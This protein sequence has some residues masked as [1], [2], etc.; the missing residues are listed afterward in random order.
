MEELFSKKNRFLVVAAHPDDEVLAIGGILALARDKGVE[1]A[2]QFLGEGV[3]A[4]FS[5]EEFDNHCYQM[6]MN[7][8]MA[9]AKAAL[10]LLGIEKVSYE[11]HYCCR[12]DRLD[13]LDLVKLIESQIAVFNPT[14]IFTHNPIEVNIDHRIT[15]RAVE[16]ATRPKPRSALRGVYSFEIPCSGN[17]TFDDSFKP[18]LYVDVKKVWHD[19]IAAWNCYEGEERDFPFPRS[20]KGLETMA[21]YRGMQA[22]LEFAEG[23]R[24]LRGLVVCN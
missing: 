7:L 23:L 4:R 2:V 19:K 24:L 14:H 18:N 17:W 20:V 6:A 12:F 22:G 13:I 8:R 15:Y 9:G 16:A 10:S 3:S 21:Q 11:N 5:P 1:V